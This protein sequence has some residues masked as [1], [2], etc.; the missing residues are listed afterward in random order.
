MNAHHFECYED[1]LLSLKRRFSQRLSQQ[2]DKFDCMVRFELGQ[3]RTAVEV[4]LPRPISVT[5]TESGFGLPG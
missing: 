3:S 2:I 1:G 4:Q 5:E